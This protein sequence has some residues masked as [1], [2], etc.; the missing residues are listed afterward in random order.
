MYILLNSGR[1]GWRENREVLM[2]I[3]PSYLRPTRR[4]TPRAGAA[5]AWVVASV[6]ILCLIGGGLLYWQQKKESKVN[7]VAVNLTGPATALDIGKGVK[8]E[9]VRINPGQ[10]MMGSFDTEPD[11]DI[12][13]SPVHKV[14]IGKPFYIGKFEVTQPQ[15]NVIRGNSSHSNVGDTFPADTISWGDATKWCEEMSRNLGVTIRLPTEAEWEYACR[16]G[17]STPFAFGA[18]LTPAQANFTS[19]D[20]KANRGKTAPVGSGKPNAWG[21]YDMHGNVWE[22]CQDTLQED[23]EKAP[24]D[25]SA[26]IDEAHNKYNRVRRGGSWKEPP[27]NCRSAVRFGSSSSA[28]EP[29]MRND[30]LG[31]RVVVEPPPDKK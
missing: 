7:H 24:A 10:F 11:H 9:L 17:T 15:W 14:T 5:L 28:E 21:L 2:T 3:N 4:G 19:S 8:L 22:W 18:A 1:R 31:F 26:W 20:P 27:A 23:Y 30:Q 16:A 13:E 25:G 6:I 29:D 12:S